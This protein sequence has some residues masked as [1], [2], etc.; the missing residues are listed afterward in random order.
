MAGAARHPHVQARRVTLGR[1]LDRALKSG[2]HLGR[3]AFRDRRD[4]DGA[5]AGAVGLG[6]QLVQC[7]LEARQ[8]GGVGVAELHLHLG[9]AGDDA[10]RVRV[11]QDAADRPH[12]ARLAVPAISAKRSWMRAASRTS[13]AAASLRRCISVVPA[14]FCSP[15]T[16]TQ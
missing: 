12:R 13:A 11:D 1:A 14:W 16:V 4:R 6:D 8:D 5:G 3:L 10:R 9:A 15:V 7:L 2:V